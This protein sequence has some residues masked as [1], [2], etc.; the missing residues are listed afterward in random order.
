MDFQNFQNRYIIQGELVI[1]TALHIGSGIE[2]DGKDAPFIKTGE[3]GY[4]IPGSTMRG[5]LRAK[6]ERFLNEKNDI[7]LS[8][9]GEKLNSGDVMMLFGY[10]N[11]DK[12]DEVIQNRILSFFIGETVKSIQSMAGRIHI[13]D[14]PVIT[15]TYEIT[16][17]GIKI[18]SDTGTVATGAKFDYNVLPAGTKFNFEL[19]GENLM[20][21]QLDLL[22]LALMDIETGDIFGGKTARGIGKCHLK[23]KDKIEYVKKENRKELENY[24]FKGVMAKADSR[25]ILK[26]KNLKII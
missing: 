14:M 10:T 5:Y 18:D 21:Y 22:K 3:N 15:E 16:R 20:D 7:G 12:Y 6:L 26:I 8:Y 11:L 4:Y 1:E 9:N 13:G 17:D 24:I 2:S 23:L 25:E 19:S